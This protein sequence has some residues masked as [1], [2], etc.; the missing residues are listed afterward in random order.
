MLN[1]CFVDKL[2]IVYQDGFYLDKQALPLKQWIHFRYRHKRY[3]LWIEQE[4]TYSYILPCDLKLEKDLPKGIPSLELKADGSIESLDKIWKKGDCLD[5]YHYHLEW[6]AFG[7][8]VNTSL[9]EKKVQLETRIRRE[10]YFPKLEK[11]EQPK[12]IPMPAIVAYP[13][14]SLL[15]QMGPSL[16][17]T[18]ATLMNASVQSFR[19]YEQGKSQ[20]EILFVFLMPVMMFVSIILWQPLNRYA[21]NKQEKKNKETQMLDYQ[22]SVQESWLSF[23]KQFQT[24][25]ERISQS[26]FTSS[27]CLRHPPSLWIGLGSNHE[28]M[29]CPF[30]KEIETLKIENFTN[31]KVLFSA[32]EE[33]FIQWIKKW[34]ALYLAKDIPAY[35]IA[36]KDWF[37]K[38][39]ELQQL[40]L[41][42]H[43]GKRH[44]YT[45]DDF[46]IESG[47]ILFSMIPLTTFKQATY[48][49]L[50]TQSLHYPYEKRLLYNQQEIQIEDEI[51]K[52]S[53]YLIEENKQEY[54]ANDYQVHDLKQSLSKQGLSCDM[55]EN[56][57]LD[58][59]ETGMGPHAI[60]TGTT[61]SGKSEFV[62]YW[63]LKMAC[64]NTP[65]QLQILL[66]DFK[67]ESLKQ[68]L[69]NKGKPIPYINASISDLDIDEFDR[70][71]YGLEQECRYRETLFQKASV[72]L[73]KP[74]TSLSQYQTLQKEDW[75][76]LPEI[77]L[78]F[79]EFAQFK[80]RFPDKLNPFITL[81]RIGRSLGIHFILITQKASGIISEQ[82]WAN[83][84]L[85]ICMKV[86]DKQDCLD[87]LHEDRR[88]DLKL[89][90]DFIAHYDEEYQQG[91]CPYLEDFITPEEKKVELDLQLQAIPT[92]SKNQLRLREYLLEEIEKKKEE[93]HLRSIW[94][95]PPSS[96]L[97][98][99]SMLGIIDD[100]EQARYTPILLE[101]IKKP[102]LFLYANQEDIFT[103]EKRIGKGKFQ[104]RS[105]HEKMSQT[106]LD[107]H[108]ILYKGPL[109]L[110]R[111]SQ[112]FQQMKRIHS[113]RKAEALCLYQEKIQK[114]LLF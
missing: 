19:L 63:L 80:Q 60:I 50:S 67:G 98:T 41:F 96:N 74:I 85:R 73:Q 84:R 11:L 75:E 57:C 36:S 42:Y 3:S 110:D 97:L 10:V 39:L 76:C 8:L 38:H 65:E 26:F 88:K 9:S 13:K 77:I 18:F 1:E 81:A 87:T 40:P 31:Q 21:E 103:L 23:F 105:I 91:H 78:V 64:Q 25:K 45:N 82:I 111:I 72:S 24:Y 56:V 20:E 46:E 2:K 14:R 30:Q 68:S 71:L 106:E 7:W 113:L 54:R 47:S 83:V 43:H 102:I 37:E 52:R 66:F 29:D 114:I 33:M 34:D 16:T 35:L 94:L 12:H 101:E 44:F 107:N 27:I 109:T 53:Y 62:L 22:K 86:T 61:G 4:S 104:A 5:Y 99:S 92:K 95:K 17:M 48:F 93:N 49:V 15:L 79:D 69:M 90:G 32:S 28:N 55:G 58:L 51:K 59:S 89:A 6:H 100:Y 108:F 70:A 112:Y